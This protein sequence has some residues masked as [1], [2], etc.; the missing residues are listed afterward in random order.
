M[1]FSPRAWGWSDLREAVLT[2]SGEA[3]EQRK[4]FEGLTAQ[5][6][7]S[8]IAFLETLQVL[9]PGT[10]ALIVDEHHQPKLWPPPARTSPGLPIWYGCWILAR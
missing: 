7:D 1:T 8:L 4:A 2:H 3:L 5:E 9:A 6:Q 10:K